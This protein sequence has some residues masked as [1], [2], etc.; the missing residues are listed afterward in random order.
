MK[1]KRLI[2]FVLALSIVQG[3]TFL[4]NTNVKADTVTNSAT[5]NI[6]SNQKS[7]YKLIRKGKR[8]PFKPTG[9]VKNHKEVGVQQFN[10]GISFVTSYGGG[11][12]ATLDPFS[13]SIYWKVKPDTNWPYAFS[14][15]I[16][17]NYYD[18]EYED[19]EVSGSGALGTS[20]GGAVPLGHSGGYSAKLTGTAMNMWGSTYV[21]LPDCE[22]GYGA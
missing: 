16:E 17:V 19:F 8:T 7:T 12:S 13:N 22:C 3:S 1:K 21:V 10:P 14:G 5:S 15:Y 11:G 2:I 18:G 4:L 20:C 9:D 6:Q